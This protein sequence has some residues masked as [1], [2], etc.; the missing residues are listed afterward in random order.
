MKQTIQSTL[1]AITIATL[2]APLYASDPQPL[3]SS[4]PYA[5]DG[6][7][8][9]VGIGSE[10]Y[11]YDRAGRLRRATT[12]GGADEQLYSYD[13]YGNI[14]SIQSTVAG[15][16]F[17]ASFGVD[18][19]T[20]QLTGA[21]APGDLCFEGRYD[22]S[23]NQTRRDK[24]TAQPDEYSWDPFNLL[25]E[26]QTFRRERYIYDA[27]DERIV[28][29]ERPAGVDTIRRYTLRGPAN[30]VVRE[31]E[32]DVAANRWTLNRDYVYR[33][34]TLLASF[35]GAQ[36]TPAL[37]YHVDHLG[38]TRLITDRDGFPVSV[39]EFWPFGRETNRSAASGEPIKFTGHERDAAGGSPGEDLDYMHLRYYDPNRAR[40]LSVDPISGTP[41]RPQSWNR[42]SYVMNRPVNFFDPT[43]GYLTDMHHDM[44]Q[45]LA[46]AAGYSP[47]MA[48]EIAKYTER[49]DEDH[50]KPFDLKHPIEANEAQSAHHFTSEKRLNEL[51]GLAATGGAFAIGTF[52]HALQDTFSHA[53]YEA[54]VGHYGSA[55]VGGALGG[56]V[57]GVIGYK[58]GKAVDET[59]ANPE[60]ATTAAFGTWAELVALNTKP[61][62][63]QVMFNQIESLVQGYFA[64]EEHSAARR[65]Y[66]NQLCRMVGCEEGVNEPRVAP[67]SGQ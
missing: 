21:C 60:Y 61:T 67:E 26:L 51:R 16:P 39:Q 63:P 10:T 11:L 66:Y 24:A 46:L 25:R 54:G 34:A 9:I 59:P 28:V 22:A 7:G 13:A 41:S 12:V 62:R 38:S 32:L 57:G 43:G 65:W 47:K 15:A 52:V 55:I 58:K 4:G 5:Y 33:G 20:N 48:A 42:Y 31:L 23:G 36:T 40:F 53:G 1:A 30:K 14:V 19:L 17:T 35:S 45:I 2:C 29:I 56:V 8:N 37:H 3:W 49:V 50:R 6:S 64:T 44:T 18:A 27:N